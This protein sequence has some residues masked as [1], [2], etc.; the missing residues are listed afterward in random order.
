MHRSVLLQTTLLRKGHELAIG[1]AAPTHPFHR[2]YF[3]VRER[4]LDARIDALV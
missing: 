3:V 1:D 2:L 4:S